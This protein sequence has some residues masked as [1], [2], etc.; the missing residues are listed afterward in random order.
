MVILANKTLMCG[1][2]VMASPG[3]PL[4]VIIAVFIMLVH[5]LVILKLSP[6][7]NQSEDWTAFISSLTLTCTT[8]IGF[9]LIMDAK[10]PKDKFFSPEILGGFA[11]LISVTCILIQVG[12]TIFV[13]C[14]MLDVV[15]RMLRGGGNTKDKNTVSV[16][17]VANADDNA[18][19]SDNSKNKDQEKN[20]ST[21][22]KS[23]D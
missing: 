1:G 16:R 3:T 18:G 19:S 15:L 11:I 8:I 2:L 23:W 21:S 20:T 12:V 13:D 9:A 7:Q 17:P 4:Q 5:M 6:Y 10:A 14:N 22:I